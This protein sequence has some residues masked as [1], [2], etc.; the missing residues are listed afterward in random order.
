MRYKSLS[1]KNI[2]NLIHA[3]T[4]M[5]CVKLANRCF[6]FKIPKPINK[7]RHPNLLDQ[8]VCHCE[9]AKQPWQ[10][11]HA[12]HAEIAGS[13]CSLAMTNVTVSTHCVQ[14]LTVSRDTELDNTIE[15]VIARARSNRGNL[16]VRRRDCH[17]RVAPSQ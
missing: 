8:R 3:T 10:S 6:Y 4:P 7:K 12:G 17:S 2:K 1:V 15:F 14:L 16:F 5:K 11:G 9:G 13:R